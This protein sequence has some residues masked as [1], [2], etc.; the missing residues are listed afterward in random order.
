MPKQTFFNL[1]DEKRQRLLNAIRD[2]FSRV[3]YDD[4][5][6]NQIIHGAGIPRGSFYQYFEDKRDALE[7]LL[8]EY[9]QQVLF[10]MR[11]SIANS[12]GDLFQLFIDLLDFT[13][14]F[15]SSE[16]NNAFCRNVFADIQH[17][18]DFIIPA[19][20]EKAHSDIINI[21]LEDVMR[22]KLDIREATDFDNMLDILFPLAGYT[23]AQAFYHTADFDRVREQFIAKLKLLQRGFLKKESLDESETQ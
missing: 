8:A 22:E 13:N 10:Q 6:I 9:K 21:L 1:S 19:M 3:S 7:Y 20:H 17:N 2:E 5:S 23:Y 16:N 12:G 4:V 15:L 11:T 14:A 18:L